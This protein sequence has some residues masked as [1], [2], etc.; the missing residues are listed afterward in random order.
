[1]LFYRAALPLSRQTLT[2]L[3]GVIRR[4]R[5]WIGSVWRLLN[6]G[7]R[8][9][10][11]DPRLR[12]AVLDELGARGQIDCASAIVDAATVRAKGG[13]PTSP[14]PSDAAGLPLVVAFSAANLHDSKAFKPLF[15]ALPT[16]RSPHGPHRRRP[17]QGPRGQGVS[18]R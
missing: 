9:R 13:T 4:H 5:R 12:R 15:M 8:K 18:L 6:P 7:Q 17:G 10:G 2:Y 11:Y 16:I 14:D 3:A 1:V